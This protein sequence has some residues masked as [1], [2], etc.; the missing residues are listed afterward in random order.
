MVRTIFDGD[1]WASA[2][3]GDSGEVVRPSSGDLDDGWLIAT[4]PN[5]KYDNWAKLAIF[6]ACQWIEEKGTFDWDSN[7]TYA[8][9]AL[10]NSAGVT[11]IGIQAGNLNKTPASEP[12]WWTNY[13][14]W[15]IEQA[16]KTM[17]VASEAA[18]GTGVIDG[19]LR[20]VSGGNLYTWNNGDTKWDGRDGNVY[21]S[22]PAFGNVQFKTGT[23]ITITGATW[24]YN[25]TTW[26]E[27][28]SVITGA[29]E[30]PEFTANDA[31][32]QI[33]LLGPGGYHLDG[34]GW[35]WW[36]GTLA[37]NFTTLAA[38][39]WSYLYID[40]SSITGPGKITNSKLTDSTTAPSYSSTKGGW[41]NGDDRC[42][43]AVYGVG[44]GSYT[45]FRNRSDLV[46]YGQ[47][48]EDVAGVAVTT[49]GTDHTLTAPAFCRQ[50]L[51]TFRVIENTSGAIVMQKETGIS[52]NGNEV[53]RTPPGATD[54]FNQTISDLNSS[55]S[56]NLH[57]NVNGTDAYVRINGWYLPKGT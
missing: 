17:V 41:Y 9:G 22:T 4:Y 23:V 1:V 8:V 48:I 15:L 54:S 34:I 16:G 36:T 40:H 24:R 12:T 42:I 20:G 27:V 56:L 53:G 52:G 29:L 33:D 43:F 45:F 32:T 28:G 3:K 55:Q 50:A 31:S 26:E 13:Y 51:A 2:V 10:V 18:L 6:E 30:R 47:D 35:V 14:D 5:R 49:G 46:T 21:S 19:Q 38:S 25:G 39:T 7:I 57:A 11:Y 37:Y 44:A